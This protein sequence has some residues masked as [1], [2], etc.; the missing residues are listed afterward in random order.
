MGVLLHW[1]GLGWPAPVDTVLAISSLLSYTVCCFGDNRAD[2]D[3]VQGAVFAASL[4]TS[5]MGP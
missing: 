4:G 2:R 3:E 5:E 1:G